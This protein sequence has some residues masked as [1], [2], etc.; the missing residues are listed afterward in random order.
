MPIRL[1]NCESPRQAARPLRA[2]PLAPRL[3]RAPRNSLSAICLLV[4]FSLTLLGEAPAQA[5]QTPQPPIWHFSPYQIRVWIALA[6][7]PELNAVL[8]DRLERTLQERAE[9]IALAP[10]SLTAE[11]APAAVRGSMLAGLE[12]LTVEH[13]APPREGSSQP[14][15]SSSAPSTAALSAGASPATAVPPGVAPENSLAEK[16]DFTNVLEKNDKLMLLRVAPDRGGYVIDARELDCR[17]RLASEIVSRRVGH[18]S[19]IPQEA[20]RA[21]TDVFRPLARIE[22]AKGKDVTVRLRAGGL[23]EDPESP[24]YLPDKTVLVPVV[25][26]NDRYGLPRENGIQIAPWAFINPQER[27]PAGRLQCELVA[28]VGTPLGGRS[29][30]RIEKYGLMAPARRDKT[31]VII[32]ARP[33]SRNDPEPPEPLAGYEV[34]ERLPGAEELTFVGRT[35]W[36]GLVEIEKTDHP[37]RVLYVKN[38]ARILAKFPVVPGLE[39]RVEVNVMNDDR[40]LEVEGFVLGLQGRI[41]DLLVAREVLALRIRKRIAEKKFAEAATLMNELRLLPSR[42]QVQA[43]LDQ[44]AARQRAQPADRATRAAIDKLFTDTRELINKHLDPT[45][46]QTLAREL[47]QA[48]QAAKPADAS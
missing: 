24:A 43:E 48:Q 28:G 26:F 37:L 45:L 15:S 19:L 6:P 17:T 46:V 29:S 11:P 7:A 30:S 25:R 3:P 23:I 4:I 31:E 42:D 27:L 38:G 9:A 47:S 14:S 2:R 32:R 44:E 36:R 12:W 33:L 13:L 18:A 22:A 41:M 8:Q 16:P 5:Q 39:P 1:A 21:I 20:F 35:D 40:R 34:H 10:W